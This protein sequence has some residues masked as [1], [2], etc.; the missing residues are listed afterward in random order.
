MLMVFNNLSKNIFCFLKYLAYCINCNVAQAIS[1][2]KSFVI[3]TF[4]MFINNV[5]WLAFWFILFYN[6]EGGSIN[7]VTLNDIIYLWS[8]PTIS[9]GLCFFLFGGV[10]DLS[11]K[12]ANKEIDNELSKP[13]H[14]LISLITS[15]AKLSAMGDLIYGLVL[16]IFAVGFNPLRYIWLIFVSLIGGIGFLGIKTQD[17]QKRFP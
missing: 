13:K 16:G 7:N 1:N 11:Y 17:H 3:Q 10:E 8:A 9:Y 15:N 12:V 5:V 6:S 14:S 2:K 4:F